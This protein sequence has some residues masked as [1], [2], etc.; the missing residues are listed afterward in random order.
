MGRDASKLGMIQRMILY[1]AR[2]FY[3]KCIF[4]TKSRFGRSFPHMLANKNHMWITKIFFMIMKVKAKIK[5]Y[6]DKRIILP[7]EE[8][9][10]EIENKIFRIKLGFWKWDIDFSLNF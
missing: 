6:K 2:I 7:R 8:F 5:T 1:C 4:G 10:W 3:L 9:S